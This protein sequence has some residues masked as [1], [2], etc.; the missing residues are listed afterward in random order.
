MPGLRA[1][2]SDARLRSYLAKYLGREDLAIRLYSWNIAL[3][4]AIW[5]PL[6]VVEVVVRNAIHGQL[7][8]RSGREDWW[9]DDRLRLQLLQRERR[10]IG[11]AVDTATRR[12]REASA[13]DVVAASNFGLWAGFPSLHGRTKTATRRTRRGA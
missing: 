4:A 13:D 11:D 6:G 8:A 2:L 10:A 9:N 5:G 1:A 3:S 7:V 12:V